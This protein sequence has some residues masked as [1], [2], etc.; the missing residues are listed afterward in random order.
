LLVQGDEPLIENTTIKKMIDLIQ[1]SEAK[2]EI[3]TFRTPVHDPIDAVNSTIIKVVTN[4]ENKVL[5]A[6]RSVIPYPKESID[7]QYFK[8]VGVYAYPRDVL[9]KWKSLRLGYIESVEEHD[10][11]RLL[12]N[13]IVVRAFPI[14][15]STISVDTPKDLERV[16]QLF[17]Q[18]AK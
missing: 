7:F 2:K 16:R 4:T 15:T 10:F 12:E 17:R 14:E 18:Q 5:F 9:L 3:F 8:S 6:S 13:E 1:N 11:M